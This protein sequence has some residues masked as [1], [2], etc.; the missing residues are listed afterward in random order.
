MSLLIRSTRRVEPTWASR[1]LYAGYLQILSGAASA[2][3]E[4][5]GANQRRKRLLRV[6]APR[7]IA[8]Q[9]W[10]RRSPAPPG[11]IRNAGWSFVS[12]THA[13]TRSKCKSTWRPR[14]AGLD[15]CTLPACKL[16]IFRQLLVCKGCG[17]Q[18]HL[19]LGRDT[20]AIPTTTDNCLADSRPSIMNSDFDGL[21][22][23]P[24]GGRKR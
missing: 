3:A 19:I 12:R 16:G 5:E 10:R 22:M 17:S 23:V 21:K 24:Q 8:L 11:T 18:K 15:D 13:P 4:L 20:I 14:P 6:A 1:P 7:I 2:A 9:W